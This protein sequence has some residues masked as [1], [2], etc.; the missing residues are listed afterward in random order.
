MS[1]A[2]KFR[3]HVTTASQVNYCFQYHQAGKQFTAFDALYV[4]CPVFVYARLLTSQPV[5][6]DFAAVQ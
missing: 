5:A 6:V 4:A 1:F 3:K 2:R